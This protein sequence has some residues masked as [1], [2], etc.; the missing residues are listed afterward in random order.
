MT[1]NLWQPTYT[2]LN[3][4]PRDAASITMQPW[5]GYSSKDLKMPT[6]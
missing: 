3:G 6:L 2:F 5:F 1:R 4:K